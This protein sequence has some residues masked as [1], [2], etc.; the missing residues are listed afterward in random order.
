MGRRGVHLTREWP[1]EPQVRA[2][3]RT[4]HDDLVREVTTDDTASEHPNDEMR[5]TQAHGPFSRYER[6]IS[7]H[8]G[9]WHERTEYELHIP[10]FTRLFAPLVRR[11][12]ARRS[13][14]SRNGQPGWAPPDRLD[15]RQVRVLGLLAAAS[16]LTA[17]VNTLFTQTVS[18]AGDDFGVG[19]WGRGV[20]GTIVRIGVLIGLPAAFLADRVGRRRV[21]VVLAWAAP[22]VV[23]LGALAPNFPLLVATQALGRPLGLALDLLIAVIAAEEMPRGSR[24]YAISVL[25]MA[26]GLG[27]GVAVVALPLAD[28]GSDGWRG[29][30]VLGL[31]WLLVARDVTRHLPETK[32]FEW[33]RADVE[34]IPVPPLQ[35]RRLAIQMSV[36]FFGNMLLSPASFFQNT[37]LQ[38]ERGFSASTVALFTIVTATPAVIGLVVGG[39]VA[40]RSGRRRLAVVCAPL[41]A[42]LIALSFWFSGPL[43]WWGAILGAIVAAAAYPPLAVYRT[44]MFPTGNRGRAAYLILASALLGG[45][46]SLLVTGA[47]VDGGTAYGPVMLALVGGPVIVALIVAFTYPETARREL[48]ELNPEDHTL[49]IDRSAQ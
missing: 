2:W 48:E 18:F 34:A 46:I 11:S 5:F 41:G 7:A 19:D 38:D 15:E 13:P 4:P 32:R 6:T 1:D 47:I 37:F 43:M 39:R 45:S 25:A 14:E 20:A 22:I 29:V 23:S 16:L 10:W 3:I 21:V 44:E 26:N 30:Y 42:L 9:K 31:L 35:K 36:A 27:A 24:A 17:F 33:H 28:I 49:P 12:L 8:D 40:D